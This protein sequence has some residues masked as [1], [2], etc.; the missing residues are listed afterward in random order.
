M[1]EDS[2]MIMLLNTL[3]PTH[4]GSGTELSFVD[5]PIQREGHTGFPK[6]EAA[7]LKGCMRYVIYQKCKNEGEHEER[8]NRIFGAPDKGDFASAISITDA[9]ILFFPVKSVAGVFGWVT[10][11]MVINRF[12]HDYKAATNRDFM[13]VQPQE[14]VSVSKKCK[15]AAKVGNTQSVMLEDYTFSVQHNKLF[16]NFLNKILTSLPDNTLIKDMLIDHTVLLSDDDF[17]SFV[18]H[19]TEIT[20]RIKINPETGTVADSALFSEEFLPPE[21]VFYSLIFFSESHMPAGTD[22]NILA[23]NQSKVKADF[24][25]LCPAGIIQIGAD[26]TLG[27]GLV[28]MG[29]LEGG[30]ADAEHGA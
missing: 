5:M 9:R 7:T 12:F 13:A 16:E 4:P 11:P 23:A 28:H 27:K 6:I 14:I 10:C 1:Y 29:F 21:T 17:A 22:K 3:T 15:L 25:D 2:A 30:N 19:S 20:T 26:R 8:I 18:Q 24:R